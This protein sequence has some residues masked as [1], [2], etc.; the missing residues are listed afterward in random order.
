MKKNRLHTK[1]VFIILSISVCLTAAASAVGYQ[2]YSRYYTAEYK[3][4]SADLVSTAVALSSKQ[5]L[6]ELSSEVLEI[7]M[8]ASRENK[9]PQV[10]DATEHQDPAYLAK[11][12]HILTSD[13]YRN[14]LNDLAVLRKNNHILYIYA[15]VIVPD[16]RKFLYLADGD[17]D[18]ECLPGDTDEW[19]EAWIRK[20]QDQKNQICTFTAKMLEYGWTFTTAVPVLDEQEEPICYI[21]VD[22]SMMEAI[23]AERNFLFSMLLMLI[24]LMIPLIVI[25]QHFSARVLIRP[26]TELNDAV[27]DF[28]SEKK[29]EVKESKI[30]KL[31]IRTGDVLLL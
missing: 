6:S 28:V 14:L 26:I 15:G 8:K 24:A 3:Q 4:V 29:G 5:E 20:L 11:Y 17:A 22:L 12:E 10:A 16:T 23:H 2:M 1:L 27:S 19:D 30:S 13:E 9:V 7:Y 25:I 18:G 21:C 31:S